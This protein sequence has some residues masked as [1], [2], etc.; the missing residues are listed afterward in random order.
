[1]VDKYEYIRWLLENSQYR[2]DSNYA[3]ASQLV[4]FIF[5]SSRSRLFRKI[6]SRVLYSTQIVYENINLLHI[7]AFYQRHHQAGHKHTEI[8]RTYLSS[9]NVF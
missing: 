7:S 1:M 3:V 6:N 5:W 9:L 2:C 4:V 8:Y